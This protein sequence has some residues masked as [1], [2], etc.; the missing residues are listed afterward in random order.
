MK[1]VISSKGKEINSLLD[2]R[3][4][5]CSFFAI[6]NDKK[7]EWEFLPNPGAL[8]GSGAGIKAAQFLIEQNPDI[9]LTGDLGPKA[10][11]ILN[12]SGIKIYSLPEVTLEEALKQY[13]QGQHRPITEA[14]VESHSG[15]GFSGN[16]SDQDGV[17]PANENTASLKGKV[18]IASDGSV[19][20]QHFGR[21]PAYTLVEIDNG[22][23]VNKNVIP[24]PGHQPGFL[25][26]FLSEKGVSCVIAGGMGPRAQN[27]FK[28]RGIN[29]IVGVTG[30]IDEVIESYLSGNL[31]GGESLCGHDGNDHSHGCENH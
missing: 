29:V 20:A 13:K 8:E 6:Y 22:K 3:F 30:P 23:P 31:I 10:A 28:E 12:A 11:Q 4:G 17:F 18:A 25:P 7:S 1:I 2:S 15:M 27:L 19:V 24:N 9:L 21:C 26:R 14:T 16:A 5:R